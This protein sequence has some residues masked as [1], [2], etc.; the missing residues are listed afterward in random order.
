MKV[1]RICLVTSGHLASNPRIVKEADA[2]HE[3]G[4]EVRVIYGHTTQGVA[5]LDNT[6]I[7]RTSWLKEKVDHSKRALYL[8]RRLRQEIARKAFDWGLSGIGCA[9]RAHSA[10]T[11]ALS[12]AAAANRADLYIAHNLPALP[13][14]YYA[15]RRHNAKMGFD[16]EDDHIGELEVTPEYSLEFRIRR[17]IE[18]HFLPR[19]QHLTSAA[20]GI[21]HA[22]NERYRVEMIPV[23][24]V[25][26]LAQALPEE[27]KS[28]SHEYNESLSLYWFSQ[29]IGPGR[30][31]EPIIL[32]LGKT[33]S[34]ITLSIR[35]SDFLEYSTRLKE[36][37]A[38]NGVSDLIFFL[39]SAPP[40]EMVRLAQAY[41]VGVASELDTPPNHAICLSN[42]IFTYLLAGRPVLL[43]DTPAQR[44]LAGELRDAAWLV[45]LDS[46]EQIAKA[47]DVWA[48]YPNELAESKYRANFLARERFNWDIEKKKI[49]ASVKKVLNES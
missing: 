25:F 40:D 45:D 37:A 36:L 18:S 39:P 41:D 43:S 5:S 6:I 4:Y 48:S 22:Y 27:K 7:A 29:T 19:C 3:A 42:K 20:P 1:K 30:G 26:P 35:G 46:P 47:L 10:I 17:R 49:L 15:A 28:E 31:L 34:R 21:S 11:L 16:A 44:E 14:I 13:A 8:A 12:K 2:L 38:E 32:A 23:L 9:V 24:N 33:R